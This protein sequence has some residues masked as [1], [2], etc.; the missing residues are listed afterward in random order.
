[1]PQVM[2]NRPTSH[3]H[4]QGLGGSSLRRKER[5]CGLVSPRQKA[6]GPLNAGC[7]LPL[8]GSW[9]KPQYS[10]LQFGHNTTSCGHLL[11][12]C[13]EGGTGAS[14]VPPPRSL[15]GACLCSLTEMGASRA[16]KMAFTPRGH[17]CRPHSSEEGLASAL[18]EGTPTMASKPGAGGS[19]RAAGRNHRMKSTLRGLPSSL[20][21][22]SRHP[23]HPNPAPR[24]EEMMGT[25]RKQR[26][27]PAILYSAEWKP[28][29]HLKCWAF[30]LSRQIVRN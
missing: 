24:A 27:V 15:R 20:L 9:L 28:Q 3:P 11:G 6:R 13:I 2:Q 29:C 14:A 8:A 25:C 1:M 10:H 26:D 4:A 19:P 12:A 21:P 5:Q 18:Q 22:R 7:P 23:R 17:Q 30:N 16:N